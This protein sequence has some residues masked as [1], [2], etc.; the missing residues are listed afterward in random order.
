M[1]QTFFK[2]I[3]IL[4]ISIILS[5]CEENNN[6]AELESKTTNTELNSSQEK[7]H[8]YANS[9][10]IFNKVLDDIENDLIESHNFNNYSLSKKQIQLVNLSNEKKESF[11]ISNLEKELLTVKMLKISQKNSINNKFSKNYLR[12]IVFSIRKHTIIDYL[13]GVEIEHIINTFV[14]F[15][16]IANKE[17]IKDYQ[18]L[19]LSQ[20]NSIIAKTTSTYKVTLQIPND[21]VKTINCASDVYILDAAEEEG[22]DLPYSCRAGA[23]STDAAKLL[24]GTIDQSD[25][26]FLDDD[27]IEC[28]MILLSVAYP[29]SDCTILTHQ[30]DSMCNGISLNEITVGGSNT[31]DPIFLPPFNGW[32]SDYY[33]YGGGTSGTGLDF[34][35]P[36]GFFND[37]FGNCV[38]VVVIVE[39]ADPEKIITN[40]DEYINCFNTSQ[41]ASLTIYVNEPID[42]TNYLI[43][44][45]RVGH[46]FV[47]IEQGNNIAS[48]GFYPDSPLSSLFQGTQGVMEDNSNTDY[49]VS[50]T[51]NNISPNNLQKIINL[52]KSYAISDYHLAQ[53]N[54][55]DM[56]IALGNLAG[57]PIPEC[58]ANPIW[59]FGSSPGELGKYMRNLTLTNGVTR[60]SN[61]GDSPSNNCN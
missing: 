56:G 30:E 28:G 54:C 37:S 10:A 46:T 20:K 41:N 8:A 25:Q 43:G 42:G 12:E 5:N 49:D 7:L 32:P 57:L 23:C 6:L 39:A 21:G 11:E 35:C 31:P 40:M 1:K 59:F 29:T 50:L 16:E 36:T 4:I 53:R 52:A 14:K 38:P 22:I 48:F 45:D 27:Q 17:F 24:S 3:Q 15:H 19:N 60:N 33:G 61:G 9:I 34:G 51:I 55:T 2:I 13:N 58:D 44:R 18:N 47:S 26:S